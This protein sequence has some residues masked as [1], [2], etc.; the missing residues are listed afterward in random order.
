[1]IKIFDENK[2]DFKNWPIDIKEKIKRII[3]ESASI[4]NLSEIMKDFIEENYGNIDELIKKTEG[5]KEMVKKE[6]E[7]SQHKRILEYNLDDM[8][9]KLIKDFVPD[10]VNSLSSL[11]K[12]VK[13]EIKKKK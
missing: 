7:E 1:M 11:C 12:D 6:E 2:I 8:V 10:F 9:S 4:E 13:S 5:C 3:D